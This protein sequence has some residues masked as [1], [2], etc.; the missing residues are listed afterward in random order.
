[1]TLTDIVFRFILAICLGALLGLERDGVW[2]NPR[3]AK[4]IQKKS[5]N[6]RRKFPFIKAAIPA[7]NIGGVRTYILLAVLGSVSGLAYHYGLEALT[8]SISIGLMVFIIISFVLNYFDKNSF[9]LTTELSIILVYTLSLLMFATD[10]PLKLVVAIAVIDA[11]VLS[12]KSELKTAIAK[13]SE[14]E[15]EDTLKFILF[16]LVILP[17]LP[18]AYYGIADIPVVGEQIAQNLSVEVLEASEIFNPQRWWMVVVFILSMNFVGYFLTRILGKNRGLNLLGLLGGLVSSTVAT[19][20][21]AESSTRVKTKSD[22]TLLL[23]ATVMANMTSF[24]RVL[25]LAMIVDIALAKLLFIPM[26]GMSAFL[27]VWVIWSTH[28]FRR[29]GKA[30]SKEIEAVGLNFDSPFKI[31]PALV[32]GAIFAVITIFTRLALYYAGDSGFVVSTMISS[33]LGLDVVT[34]N[35]ATLVGDKITYE[36]GAFVLVIAASVNLVVK[37]VLAALVGDKF[38]RLRLMQIFLVTILIGLVLALF[39]LL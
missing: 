30:K 4:E 10:V 12:M 32:F 9:G 25:F 7:D 26:M 1:M 24:V 39:V 34:I 2:K 29:S 22:K 21:L 13:F 17:F 35:T 36:F 8:I 33:V 38:Y 37:I 3:T 23:N 6:A 19:Q 31:K 28:M 14:K 20:T 18:N 15:I 5:E 16:T 11:V 27:L